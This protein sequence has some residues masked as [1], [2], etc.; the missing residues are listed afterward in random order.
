MADWKSDIVQQA[1]D[2]INAQIAATPVVFLTT[3]LVLKAS[4]LLAML[5][6]PITLLPAPGMGLMY[7]PILATLEYNPVSVDYTLGDV[8]KFCI[9]PAGGPTSL[10][11]LQSV[12]ST[13]V[14]GS[15]GPGPVI[16]VAPATNVVVSAKSSFENQAL[17]IAHDGT[18]EFSTGDGTVTVTLYYIATSC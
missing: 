8:T 10:N 15:G 5:A 9:G 7:Q 1:V 13:L 14:D 4:D 18:G 17:V 11:V 2:R 3:K 16:A 6:T 12:S